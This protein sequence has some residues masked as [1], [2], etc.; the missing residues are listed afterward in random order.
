MASDRDK[1]KT[2]R[3]IKV[4]L[5][6]ATGEVKFLGEPNPTFDPD[7]DDESEA[8]KNVRGIGL[9]PWD[10]NRR[11]RDMILRFADP[12]GHIKRSSAGRGAGW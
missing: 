7:W 8:W 12:Q 10:Y 5:H 3:E 6:G 2:L 11:V 4:N 9:G 1:K